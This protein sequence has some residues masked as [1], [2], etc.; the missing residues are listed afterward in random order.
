MVLFTECI[1]QTIQLRMVDG[2]NVDVQVWV[3]GGRGVMHIAQCVGV[4][5]LTTRHVLRCRGDIC[6]AACKV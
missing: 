3:A 1:V 6:A 2:G 4:M 5:G